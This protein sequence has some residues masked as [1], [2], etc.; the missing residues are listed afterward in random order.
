MGENVNI[1]VMC[2]LLQ[3]TSE[4][5]LV[6]FSH[7]TSKVKLETFCYTGQVKLN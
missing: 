1:S 5:K 3:G 7:G 4:V 6:F 2:F